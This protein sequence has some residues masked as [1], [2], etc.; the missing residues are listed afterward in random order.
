MTDS[1]SPEFERALI[2]ATEEF[3][4]LY[5]D[6]DS[7]MGDADLQ[8]VARGINHH[9]IELMV[10]SM[11]K[12]YHADLQSDEPTDAGHALAAII[13]IALFAG[14]SLERHRHEEFERLLND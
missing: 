5:P 10:D 6:E 4:R 7:L 9:D 13:Q 8:M 12:S 2:D 11:Y 14:M 3:R 1:F